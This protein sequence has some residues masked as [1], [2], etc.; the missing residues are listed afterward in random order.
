MTRTTESVRQSKWIAL[1]AF[2]VL[3]VIQI[4]FVSLLTLNESDPLIVGVDFSRSNP[5]VST[6]LFLTI[7]LTQIV[8]VYFI[9]RR[10]LQNADMLQ[11]HPAYPEGEE[12]E[13]KHS[14]DDVMKWT[15]ELAERSGVRVDRI[16]V[17]KSPLPN[18]F[19]FSLPFVGS[20]VVLHTNLLD[21]LHPEEVRA[22]VAHEV[23]HI[24]NRDSLTSIF[25]R[26]PAFF[27][28]VVYLYIY[29]RIG[30]GIAT[31]LL[32]SFDAITALLRILVLIAFFGLS[33]FLMILSKILVQKASRDAEL[34][35]DIHA[36]ETVGHVE[37]INGLVRLGQ[38]VEAV[39]ALIDEIKWLVALDPERISPL[40]N[41]ELRAMIASYPLDH[42]DEKNARR[43]AP[44]IFLTTRL[45]NLRD[46]YGLG[47]TDGMI[48]ETV[49]PA[50]VE[51]FKKRSLEQKSEAEEVGDLIVDWRDVDYDGD[52][53]L[54]KE[55]L[56]DLVEILRENPTKMMFES[57]LGMKLYALSHPDFR[58]RLLFL[59]DSFGF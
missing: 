20:T 35:G 7:A 31:S 45:R 15:M 18:A 48:E 38:R 41:T 1:G 5:L 42:I 8:L 57:E 24:K 58:S 55:E 37:T 39:S 32:V 52:R 49:A 12:W 3:D 56:I 22:I 50:A 30:L 4:A 44:T 11:I 2:L 36:A 21:I 34:L 26:M 25:S 16:Y 13:C 23:G 33:R 14:K 47:V 53:R 9:T 51:L 17:M 46:V 28:D 6:S 54:S 40:T 19:T 43:M 27:V 59:A 29:I 10:M